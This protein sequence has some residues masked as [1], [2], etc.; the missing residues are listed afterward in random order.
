MTR[1]YTTC[2]AGDTRLRSNHEVPTKRL[3]QSPRI[4]RVAE[5]IIC[6]DEVL[7][8]HTT[9]IVASLT[10]P[11]SLCRQYTEQEH[12]DI[13]SEQLVCK[14]SYRDAIGLD[15]LTVALVLE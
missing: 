2:A 4:P 10:A 3:E 7:N 11:T 12:A 5:E 13:C 8:Q 9:L 1:P 15:S 6:V 14:M